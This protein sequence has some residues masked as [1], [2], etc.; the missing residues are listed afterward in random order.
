MSFMTQLNPT[1]KVEVF[2]EEACDALTV[3]DLG[4]EVSLSQVSDGDDFHN[5][6]IGLEQAKALKAY[7][8]KILE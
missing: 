5:V 4:S 2:T 8:E 3:I 6:I 1:D 7:L